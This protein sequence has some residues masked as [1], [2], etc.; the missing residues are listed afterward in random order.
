MFLTA[1]EY[2]PSER[3]SW[4]TRLA[5]QDPIIAGEVT[6]LLRSYESADD[7][8]RRPCSFPVDLLDDLEVEPCRFSP[9]DVLCERFRIVHLIGKGGMGEVYKA[10]DQVSEEYVALKTLRLGISTHEGLTSRFRKEPQLG[11]KVTHPNVCRIHDS[12]R[13]P[14]GG[15]DFISIVSMEL[16]HGQSLAEHLK[17]KGRLKVEEALPLAR[18]IIS[19]LDA[20]HAAGV[21]H[22]DLKPANLV[23]V[24]DAAI[25]ATAGGSQ[26]K[27]TEKKHRRDFQVKIT[28]F[29]IAGQIPD[30]FSSSL[31]SEAS[32]F[33]GTPDYMAPEQLEQGETSIQS[34]I[35]A[36]GLILYQMITGEKPFADAAWKRVTSEPPPPHK[37]APGLPKNW[38]KTILCCLERN[39][40]HRFQN[41]QDVLKGLEGAEPLVLPP[42][43]LY[44]RF[45]RA[46]KSRAGLLAI[47]FL[48]IVSL[49]VGIYRYFYQRPEIPPGTMVL[50]ID[51][52]TPDPSLS[53]ITVA[54]KELLAQ[55]AHFEVEPPEKVLDVLTQMH[56]EVKPKEIADILK[57]MNQD[58][59]K[60]TNA[61]AWREVALRSRARWVVYGT[62]SGTLSSRE[63]LKL[64]IEVEHPI[65]PFFPGMTWKQSFHATDDK[66]FRDNTIHSA[67][68]WIR[69]LAGEQ[70]SEIGSQDRP[71][72]D[73]STPSWLALKL[74]GE[75]E[76][77]IAM[78]DR[79]AA[80]SLL[81]EAVQDDPDF[82][83]SHSRIA[84]ILIYQRLYNEGYAEWKKAFDLVSSR[85]LTNRE[86][87]RIQGQY[88]EDT[89][90]YVAAE[91]KYEEYKIHYPN[92][93][94]AWFYWASALNAMERYDPAIDAFA[95]AAALKPKDRVAPAHLAMTYMLQRNF[96]AAKAEI[97]RIANLDTETEKMAKLNTEAEK[98]AKVNS[99]TALWLAANADFLQREYDSA[100]EKAHRLSQSGSTPALRSQGY[101][102]SGKFLAELGRY[103]GAIAAF[104]DGIKFDHD[105]GLP[106]EA[107]KKIS[108]AYLYFREGQSARARDLALEA[109]RPPSRSP[110]H[111]LDAGTLLA[112]SG[113]LSSTDQMITRLESEPDMPRIRL[114]LA[115]LKGE[116]ALARS[117]WKDAISYFEQASNIARPSENRAYL[118]NGLLAGGE[119]EKA[120]AILRQLASQQER[121]LMYRDNDFPGLYSDSLFQLIEHTNTSQKEDL[122]NFSA[123]YLQLRD[124]ADPWLQ[125]KEVAVVRE[126][127]GRVCH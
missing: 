125:N 91:K 71:L 92:D 22:R 95:H 77:K 40:Q 39:P 81:R 104:T 49:A 87:L 99:D 86:S 5:Q 122:C 98:I 36:V 34:D 65:S 62:L 19:G 8:L 35:Y 1:L 24:A 11:R 30:E 93:Y 52:E 110:H 27:I 66:D 53:G 72:E 9:S 42:K 14:V 38:D 12:F 119:T 84:D 126:Q 7:F 74:Y 50:V 105:S 28:D 44:L 2:T 103:E 106:A 32:K 6:R 29:G 16:L 112:R 75:A 88:Y 37:A 21:L 15:E 51:I 64:T 97:D 120:D 78:Q 96:S 60:A 89:G 83:M 10:W 79:N 31:P 17:E 117:R 118:A 69:K 123:E 82:A 4:L 20:I 70:E 58:P 108:L 43:P 45:K 63:G 90:D 124:K 100:L 80:L 25:A 115:R 73:I 107:D 76:N 67:S 116:A 41:A 46:A 48:L 23:L 127:R 114:A 61:R 109:V 33:L 55:S 113:D 3:E 54:L 13:H 26:E 56:P 85:K 102:Q 18:Q 57:Q 121:I 94:F 111:L 47:F 59:E 68:T 101:D